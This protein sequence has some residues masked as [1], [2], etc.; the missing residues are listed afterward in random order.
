MCT[1]LNC[2]LPSPAAMYYL[3]HCITCKIWITVT[4]Q[5]QALHMLC[6]HD[7]CSEA[8]LQIFSFENSA[9]S[10][11]CLQKGKLLPKP[12]SKMVAYW[13]GH[14]LFIF[15]A[16]SLDTPLRA[17]RLKGQDS[18][19]VYG[20]HSETR[21]RRSGYDHDW[22]IL[23]LFRHVH[24]SLQGGHVG[25]WRFG[26]HLPLV[27]TL[28]ELECSLVWAVSHLLSRAITTDCNMKLLRQQSLLP[29]PILPST[30]AT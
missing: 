11:R 2:F 6:F 25:K 4:V 30:L 10:C 3:L 28:L 13:V 16:A 26:R 15:V 27:G 21:E 22:L 20:N 8:R 24:S 29:S 19:C 14:E 17:R 9:I 12:K 7:S 18:L 1:Y 5:T 23:G